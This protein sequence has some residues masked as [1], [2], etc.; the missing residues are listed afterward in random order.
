MLRN[1]R[2]RGVSVWGRT[3]K[4][5]N[6]EP[7]RKVSRATSASQ[8]RRVEVPEW[9]I[10]HEELGLAVEARRNE[11][12]AAFHKNGGTSYNRRDGRPVYEV[13]G[14]VTVADE[15]EKCRKQLVALAEPV[16]VP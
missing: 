16:P 15:S 1:E 6:P 7:E 10:I 13:S 12:G 14:N 8:W 5:R 3:Q 11:S 9:R 4:A 2:Y